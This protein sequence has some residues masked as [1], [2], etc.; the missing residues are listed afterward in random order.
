M[1]GMKWAALEK[2]I[3]HSEASKGSYSLLNKVVIEMS[4]TQNCWSCLRVEDFG[5]SATALTLAGSGE[6]LENQADI[7][8]VLVP[9]LDQD[10]INV[11][12]DEL[13]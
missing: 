12:K 3:N 8:H 2:S 11:H 4:K 13:I 5:H 7:L 9:R 1:R 10:I 6:T